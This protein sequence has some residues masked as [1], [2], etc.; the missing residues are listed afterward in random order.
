VVSQHGTTC[1][2]S[3]LTCKPSQCFCQ[4]TCCSPCTTPSEWLQPL[5]PYCVLLAVSCCP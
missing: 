4:P 2:T 5:R 3:A 1:L